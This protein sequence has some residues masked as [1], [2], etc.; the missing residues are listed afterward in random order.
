MSGT[1]DETA[2]EEPIT[3]EALVPAA[4]QPAR[5]ESLWRNRDYL[6]LWSGQA[7]SSVGTNV[8]QFAFPLLVLFLTGSPAQAGLIGASRTVPYIFLSLPVGALIDRW[9]RKRVMILC[10]TGRAIALGSIPVVYAVLGTVSIA[11][12]YLA[13]LIEGT[14]YVLFNIAEVACLPR[15]VSKEQLPAATGQNQ[16]SEISSVLVGSPLGGA[17]YAFSH[18]LPFLA[19]AISY[20]V[21]VGSLLLIKTTFQGERTVERRKLRDEI[22]EGLRWLWNQPLIRFMAFLTGGLNFTAGL[23][24]LIIVIAQRQGA[25]TPVIGLVFTIGAIGGVVGSVIGPAIQKRFRFGTVIIVACWIQAVAWL[26]YVFQPNVLLLGVI[27]AVLFVSGPVYNVV[28]F[29]YRLALIPD[30]LQGRVNSVF[31]LLAFGFIPI[32]QALTGVLLQWV[33]VVPTVLIFGACLIGL[34]A[35]T[36]IN[37]HVRHA[38]PLEEVQAA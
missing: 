1:R 4:G 29:S 15:V 17:L 37:P 24:L 3:R 11:Q 6:L 7:I 9:D 5:P 32:G 8:S 21:S 10:D 30:E 38:R 19:D 26:F 18:L 34:A 23:P 20:V 13:A 35:A 12:L 2:Q 31:R 25:P 14:L 33:D 28:Q 22:G 16:A 36:T 27:S